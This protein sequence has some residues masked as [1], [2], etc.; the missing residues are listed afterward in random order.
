MKTLLINVLTII[1]LFLIPNVNFGQAPD[2]GVASSFALFTATG[3]F[4]NT[5]AT[6]VIGDV[7]TNAGEFNAFPPGTVDG[8][9]HVADG[10]SDL[11]ATDVINAYDFMTAITC[12]TSLSTPFGNGQ[13]L[14]PDVYCTVAAAQLQGNLILDGGGNPN[15]IFIF[16]INGALTTTGFSSV[17]LT[18]GASLCNI[19]WQIGGQ[20]DLDDGSVFRG[21]AIV[22]GAIN[23]L[24]NSS[25]LGRGLSRAG[26]ISLVNNV[27]RFLPAAATTIVGATTVC[28]GQ[29]ETFTVPEIADAESYSWTLP[30]GT[31]GS[32]TTNSIDVDF[33]FSA[34]SGNIAV[35]GYNSCGGNGPS[36]TLPITV[37]PLPLT[38]LI[39]HQ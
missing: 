13:V 28:P 29:T 39:Y 9:I 23:L 1:V 18:N 12:G 31:T 7:G 11:A 10:T 27:V 15:S 30:S 33:S 17:T 4:N 5:G 37:N 21:T 34:T 38:S 6:Y 14:S 2:L 8:Q 36:S 19:Y 24:G 32:S 26:A 3:A 16:K 25:L 22:D 20:F 35:S